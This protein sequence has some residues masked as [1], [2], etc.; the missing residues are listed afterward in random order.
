MKRWLVRLSDI[1]PFIKADSVS[2]CAF[3]LQALTA[4]Q[5]S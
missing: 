2:V 1:L 3:T 4:N 5:L